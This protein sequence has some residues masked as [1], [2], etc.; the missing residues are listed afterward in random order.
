M[1]FSKVATTRS[2][3]TLKV[4]LQRPEILLEWSIGHQKA[5]DLLTELPQDVQDQNGALQ[6]LFAGLRTLASPQSTKFS[7]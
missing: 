2:F 4:L 1:N 7:Y 5:I 6:V 3:A